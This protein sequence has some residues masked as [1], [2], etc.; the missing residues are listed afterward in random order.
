MGV[1]LF[2]YVQSLE[3]AKRTHTVT[4]PVLPINLGEDVVV[5]DIPASV[6]MTMRAPVDAFDRIDLTTL[7][8]RL[9]VDLTNASA[10]VKEYRTVP[11]VPANVRQFEW[12]F[13]RTLEVQ[14]EAVRR[15]ERPVEVVPTGEPRSGFEFGNSSV[16]PE[17]V[18][19]RGAESQVARIRT[20]RVLLNL[21]DER[22]SQS[23]RQTVEV[24]DAEGR[25]LRVDVFPQEVT[26]TWALMPAEPRWSMIVSPV[27]TGQPEPGFRIAGYVV[28]PPAVMVRGD[29]GNRAEVGSLDTETISLEGLNAT[30]NRTV[31]LRIPEGLR[32]SERTVNVRILVEPMPIPQPQPAPG[33]PPATVPA[34]PPPPAETR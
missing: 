2:V 25:P 24:L 3:L 21:S 20:V 19:V 32:A 12:D 1:S 10:G 23:R 4:A 16:E 18:T 5:A 27:F 22:S 13:P 6:T 26:V 15:V 30:V 29:R 9:F 11:D 14:L 7:R 33:A 8:P 28:N 17:T 34:N 31:R